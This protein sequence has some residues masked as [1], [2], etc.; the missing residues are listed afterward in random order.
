M[1]SSIDATKPISG[2]PTTQ[3]VRDNFSAAKSEIETL[4][5]DVAGKIS[6]SSTD[7]LTNKT[8]S[9]AI[10]TLSNIAQSSITN[11]ISDLAARAQ[12]AVAN[13]FTALNRFKQTTCPFTTITWASTIAPDLS[14][15]QAFV[16]TATGATTLNAPT[17]MDS[18][19]FQSFQ[20]EFI[21]DATGGRTLSFATGTNGYEAAGASFPVVT[22]TANAKTTLYFNRQ[23]NGKFAVSA[24]LDVRST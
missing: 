10:N 2:T 1:A 20:L 23:S 14:Q 24:L 5:S 8:I 12:L 7:T 17:N 3:S 15:G 22:S 11:L 13:V 18:S 19:N 16:V 21:Q 4:Q 9:G 6:A